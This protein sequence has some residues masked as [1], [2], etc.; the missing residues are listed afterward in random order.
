MAN[1]AVRTAHIQDLANLFSDI[2]NGTLPAVS[3]TKPSGLVDGHPSSSKLDLFESYVEKILT[4][5]QANPL[6]W[7]RDGDHRYLR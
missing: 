3:F 1:A 6:L 4:A 7:S 2:K 5:V